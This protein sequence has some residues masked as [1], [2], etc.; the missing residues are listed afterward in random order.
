M[1]DYYTIIAVSISSLVPVIYG[2]IFSLIFTDSGKTLCQ[3]YISGSDNKTDI[4]DILRMIYLFILSFFSLVLIVRIAVPVPSEGWLRTL[5]MI[6][7]LSAGSVFVFSIIKLSYPRLSC[8]I[9]L[10]IILLFM[11]AVP[12]GLLSHNPWNYIMFISPFYWVSWAWIIPSAPESI[13]YS[14]I[15]IILTIVYLL[16]AGRL[17]KR[18]DQSEKI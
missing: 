6:I 2:I 15:A 16:I 7:L 1:N 9:L 8:I 14:G 17:L 12:A 18:R 11:A 13:A 5:F 10:V 3:L 4:M